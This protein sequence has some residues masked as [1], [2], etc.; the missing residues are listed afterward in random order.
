MSR[1]P[2]QSSTVVS[3]LP[4]EPGHQATATRPLSDIREITE[5]SLI[6][7]VSR[8][9]GAQLQRQSS[10]NRASSLKR[11]GSVKRNGSV[12]ITEPG[13]KGTYHTRS[14]STGNTSSSYSD[15]PAQGSFYSIPP[16]SVPRRS[17]SQRRSSQRRQTHSRGPSNRAE[18]PTPRGFTIANHGHSESP[19]KEVGLRVDP[20]T[21]EAAR[22]V[23]SRTFIRTAH[24]GDIPSSPAFKHPRVRL[25]LQ[26]SAPLFV[27]GGSIEGFVKIT[28][29]DNERINHRRS[30]SIC[31]ISV[32]LVGY[33]EMTGGSSGRKATFLALGTE[34]LDENN[35]P[36]PNMVEPANPIFFDESWTLVPSA[37]ALPFMLSLPLDTGP[38][39]FQSKHAN[40]R[41]LLS[42]TLQIK[43]TG[44]LYRV[45]T[46]HTVCV[47]GTHDPEK[48]L[49]S[50]PSPLTASDELPLSRSGEAEKI[51][52][53]AG[54]HRQVW[55]SGSSIFVDVHIANKS[56]KIVKRLDL[57]LERN[58]LCYRHAAAATLER[59]AGQA[60]IF[61]S[62]EQTLLAKSTMRLGHGWR[63]VDPFTSDTRTC[64]L[65]VPRGHATVRCGKYF[66]VR[67][68]L[69]VTAH[70]SSSKFVSVQLPI[71]LIHMNS[72]D[73]LP[74]SVAQVAAAIEEKR[75]HHQHQRS[76]SR[77]ESRHGRTRS[78]SSPAPSKPDLHRKPS[79]AQGRAFA[80]PRQQSLDRQRAKREDL[81]QLTATL[82]SSPRKHH[83][84]AHL[85]RK[86]TSAMSIGN[87]HDPNSHKPQRNLNHHPTSRPPTSQST[88]TPSSL[89]DPETGHTVGNYHSPASNRKGRHFG[90]LLHNSEDFEGLRDRLRRMRSFDSVHSKKSIA[91][92]RSRKAHLYS[93]AATARSSSQHTTARRLPE[94]AR[95][96]FGRRGE[97][98]SRRDSHEGKG[99]RLASPG[100]QVSSLRSPVGGSEVGVCGVAT[101]A[102]GSLGLPPLGAGLDGGGRTGVDGAVTVGLGR[103][104]ATA[105]EASRPAL[106]LGLR[107]KFDRGRFEVRGVGKKAAGGSGNG[108]GSGG[109]LRERGRGWWDGFRGRERDR[110]PSQGGEK[111]GSRQRLVPEVERVG[112]VWQVTDVGEGRDVRKEMEGWI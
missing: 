86:L 55:V 39:P 16:S 54:L 109:G 74:N 68:F 102:P 100:L 98:A 62:N 31:A 89:P 37:S 96:A 19:V 83:P 91:T 15:S 107:E 104:Q 71:I 32:D 106:G 5:P 34:L 52:L 58:I 61:E 66:E 111:G 90:D 11:K 77:N 46:S 73:V 8:W 69:N 7:A 45:R 1:T 81:A 50:L 64:D 6:D 97:G 48:A 21:S 33:E 36:P 49:T 25:E 82:E 94:R 60:R 103:L 2:P 43:D 14:K 70:I 10:L 22:R 78:A 76:Q 63:G 105:V 92:V 88:S 75:A 41:F 67:Y 87:F 35:H 84:Q 20:Y 17:S 38:P 9:P 108:S 24:P 23:P 72:L 65:E 53:T 30:L 29:D 42:A 27:G 112:G 18:Q 110:A 79:Y 12:R 95:S 3:S 40:I 57:T 59:S 44:K 51:K 28:V 101:I 93:A 4:S 26:V 56:R 80:A 85:A 99:V 47:L 13:S